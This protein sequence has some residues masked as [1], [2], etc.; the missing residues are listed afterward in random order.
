MTK[1]NTLKDPMKQDDNRFSLI[2]FCPSSFRAQKMIK[3]V[4]NSL[5]RIAALI[6]RLQFVFCC[7]SEHTVDQDLKLWRDLAPAPVLK[8]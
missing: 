2:I 7:V 1:Q 4:V 8:I 3:A 6:Q 5:G